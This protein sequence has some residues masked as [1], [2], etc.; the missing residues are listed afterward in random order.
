MAKEKTKKERWG[1]FAGLFFLAS[2]CASLE[3]NP[4]LQVER[5]QKELALAKEALSQGKEEKAMEHLI[6]AVEIYPC[7]DEARNLLGVLFF[8]KGRFEDARVQFEWA[9][10]CKDSQPLYH[11]NLAI[12][13]LYLQQPGLAVPP[14]HRA[15]ELDPKEVR[16]RRA[17]LTAQIML[18]RW[19]DAEELLRT[20]EGVNEVADSPYF[21]I[22]A[23]WIRLAQGRFA[24]AVSLASKAEDKMKDPWLPLATKGV[25][26]ELMGNIPLAISSYQKAIQYHP[27]NPHLYLILGELYHR[28]GY[29]ASAQDQIL[30]A[31]T[32]ATSTPSTL[33]HEEL[34]WGYWTLADVHYQLGLY[35]SVPL[36]LRRVQGKTES[37]LTPDTAAHYAL[38][39]RKQALKDFDGAIREFELS[40]TASPRFAL[41]W[42]RLSETYLDKALT[43]PL[44]ERAPYIERAYLSARRVQDLAPQLSYGYYMEGKALVARSDLEENPVRQGTLRMALFAFSKAVRVGSP[45]DL[46][47]G[48]E[49]ALF[50][51][52]GNYEEASRSFARTPSDP[53]LSYELI[54]NRIYSLLRAGRYNEIPPLLDEL[55]RRYPQDPD[56][57]WL[58]SYLKGKRIPTSSIPATSPVH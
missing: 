23:S 19:R 44:K 17:L 8:S 22:E 35:A 41:G 36:Y 52:L 29:Y 27:E 49:G 4:A 1:L 50:M 34:N 53:A 25:I 37:D 32:L 54:W 56:L 40:I 47:A 7:Q 21:L 28:L 43:L 57:Q 11:Y 45:P 20:L 55:E 10:H 30:R 48:Y 42:L 16:Y 12:T 15:I 18:K 9:I 51:S 38:G 6:D 31:I 39:I 2:S 58:L 24:E 14:I 13:H 33:S 46:L 26:F 5:A 3:K